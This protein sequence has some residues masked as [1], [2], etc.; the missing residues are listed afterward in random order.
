MSAKNKLFFK[1]IYGDDSIQMI[2]NTIHIAKLGS[3]FKRKSSFIKPHAHNN[4]F[5]LFVIESGKL[6]LNV[7]DEQ[8]LL[9]SPSFFTIPKNTDHG[10]R[11]STDLKGYVISLQDAIIENMLQMDADMIISIDEVHIYKLNTLDQLISDAYTTI[12][13]CINEY[14]SN[15]PAKQYALQYL[16]GMLLLR[17]Y[18]IP[19]NSKITYKIADNKQTIIYRRFLQLIKEK[20][21][22]KFSV[23]QYA[24]LLHISSGHL[25]K[26]CNEVSGKSPKNII[27]D[28][29]MEE[30]KLL[31]AN[32]DLSIAEITYKIG[33][34]DPGYL[35]RLFKKRTGKTPK[36]YRSS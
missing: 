21:D 2:R 11:K 3:S 19:D 1:G 8:I 25:N 31:L 32:I 5:Q 14:E 22:F 10:F 16:V 20:N 24:E 34:N 26:I 4:L 28:Y 30:V 15:L 13:K 17:L 9:E 18:R 29:Y 36:Q 27:I 23:K 6:E 7:N 12:H 35:T 33:L